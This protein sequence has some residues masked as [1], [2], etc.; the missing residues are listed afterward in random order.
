MTINI[1]HQPA[2][3]S[4]SGNPLFLTVQSNN[5]SIVYFKVVVKSSMD[6]SI[7]TTLKSYVTPDAPTVGRID[8]SNLLFNFTSTPLNIQPAFITSFSSGYLDYYLSITEMIVAGGAIVAGDTIIIN[9]LVTYNGDLSDVEF[10]F[11]GYRNYY[12]NPITTAKFLSTKPSINKINPWSKE[13]LYFLA[14]ASSTIDRA[15]VKVYTTSGSQVYQQSFTAGGSK[16]HRLNISP[17]NLATSLNI[18]FNLVTKFEVYLVNGSGAVLSEVKTYTCVN[19]PCNYELVNVIW[20]N[21]IGGVNSYTFINP[22]ETKSVKRS[23]FQTNKY[24]D[25]SISANGIINNSE[26]TYNVSQLSDYTVNSPIL[27]DWE[28]VYL[29]DMLSSE[30]VY[31]ELS[32]G[33]FYP[34]E[35]TTTSAEV[36]RKKYSTTAPRFQFTYQAESNL[37]IVPNSYLSFGAGLS[38]IGFN[39]PTLLSVPLGYF[40]TLIGDGSSLYFTINHNMQSSN[41]AIDL[42]YVSNGQTV[43][44]DV[45]R[46]NSNTI[47]VE[48]ATP[49]ATNSVKVMISKLN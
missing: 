38:Q 27:N 32:D 44:G 10:Q 7:V 20:K 19:L 42:V 34:I 41:V 43:F 25:Y 2:K 48:F 9:D 26:K 1:Q 5:A 36:K 17:K 45:V 15:I 18:D 3:Y 29:T 11:Y 8:L 47:S 46:V 39:V 6:N 40:E 21:K 14:D 16:L 49:I 22:K 28:Y 30:Q 12:I 31:I 35:L 24:K 4:P 37:N 33:S 13:F 23:S